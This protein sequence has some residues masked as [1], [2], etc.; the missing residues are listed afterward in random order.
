[1]AAVPPGV[2]G[3]EVDIIFFCRKLSK[4]R[5][6]A[7]QSVGPFPQCFAVMKENSQNSYIHVDIS[8][9]KKSV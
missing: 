8:L 9:D 7:V 5:M 2:F 4:P 1:M 6:S 3:I